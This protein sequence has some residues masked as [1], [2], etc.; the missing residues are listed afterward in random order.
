[1][2][3]VRFQTAFAGGTLILA[4]NTFFF[5]NKP[6]F[7]VHCRYML[8]NPNESTLPSTTE[9]STCNTPVVTVL[10][11][12]KQHHLEFSDTGK[13]EGYASS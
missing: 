5:F 13:P 6:S 1:M 2:T 9:I 12:A 7:Y 11:K 4:T 10:Y 3:R 8:Q